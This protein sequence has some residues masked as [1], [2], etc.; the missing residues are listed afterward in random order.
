MAE[1]CKECGSTRL[2]KWYVGCDRPFL[3]ILITQ[4][5]YCKS[6]KEEIVRV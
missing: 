1:Y 4:C 2:S 6:Q 3:K 5:E